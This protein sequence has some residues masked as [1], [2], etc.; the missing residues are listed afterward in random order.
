M[1]QR[2]LLLC[3]LFSCSAQATLLLDDNHEDLWG[4]PGTSWFPAMDPAMT[5]E[6]AASLFALPQQTTPHN[7]ANLGLVQQPYWFHFQVAAT[8]VAA[9]RAWYYY[10]DWPNFE[11]VVLYQK[12]GAGWQSIPRVD[13]YTLLGA[14]TYTSP[15]PLFALTL[16]PDQPTDFL[17][18][19]ESEEPLLLAPRL[20]T[21]RAFLASERQLF[22]LVGLYY[23]AILALV[24]Y[25][26][27]LW[28]G[29]RDASYLWYSLFISLTALFFG[30][31]QAFFRDFWPH[32]QEP[33]VWLIISLVLTGMILCV[34]Q[35]SRAFLILRERDPLMHR[36]AYP[37]ALL[38][39]S[40]PPVTLL[41]SGQFAILYNILVGLL[42]TAWVL[43][44]GFRAARARFLP[45]FI[46]LPAWLVLVAGLLLHIAV[47]LGLLRYSIWLVSGM[48]IA[49]V[50]EVIL[51]SIALSYRIRL[52]Q[53]ER[54]RL[55]RDGMRLT[56]L[57]VTD[58]LTGLF[59][60]RYWQDSLQ[61][62]VAVSQ[63]TGQSMSLVL[64]DVDHFK[65]WNDQWGHPAGDA[66]LVLLA[67]LIRD[68][69]RDR[70]LPC[71][72]GGEEFGVI[73][74]D[75]G[76]AQAEVMAGR[77]CDRVRNTVL[78]PV[79]GQQEQL[80]ISLGVASLNPG[81]TAEQ[82]LQRCDQALY[83]AKAE[84]RDRVVLG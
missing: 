39:M 29:L 77:L 84:G 69:V 54:D 46:L 10:L 2:L 7:T 70:D 66:A 67:Q 33:W 79:S 76:L 30:L 28:A 48:Q 52:L 74:P 9:T 6:Q 47:Y 23:G 80:T 19:I 82:L 56:Q 5:P 40:L 72:L 17:L 32:A 20:L 65:R 55:E 49:S 43:T 22:F 34:L 26:L 13:Q 24:I 60:R 51:L 36:L 4:M 41:A 75:T 12:T 57:S 14:Q 63:A 50:V 53:K 73:L 71:R 25:N 58:G 81:E 44:A 42:I 83:R 35:F 27:F 11:R 1:L 61:Q 21:A 38:G 78:H 45:A 68:S 3:W 59:N 31:N 62:R 8:P 15:R 64:L 18:L 37:A 16:L